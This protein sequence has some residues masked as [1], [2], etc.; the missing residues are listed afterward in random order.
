[1]SERIHHLSAIGRQMLLRDVI[2]SRMRISTIQINLME[3][4]LFEVLVGMRP[5]ADLS[6]MRFQVHRSG[7]L[8]ASS[9]GFPVSISI[10]GD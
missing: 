3:N 2:E 6:L 9:A 4:L 10:R 8:P 1:M 7:R 5:L